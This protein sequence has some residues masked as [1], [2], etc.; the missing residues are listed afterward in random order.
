VLVLVPGHVVASIN[1]SPVN[2]LGEDINGGESVVHGLALTVGEC[3]LSNT[4]SSSWGLVAGVLRLREWVDGLV[5]IRV[6]LLRLGGGVNA[7]PV[8]HWGGPV[9]VRLDIKVVDT[10][11]DSEETLFAPVGAPRVTN[12]PELNTVLDTVTNNGNNVVGIQEAS[13]IVENTTIVVIE[14]LVGGDF[15]SKG[16]TLV[17]FVLNG[18]LTRDVAVLL[19][20]VLVVLLGDD[21][22]SSRSAVSAVRHGRATNTVVPAS[23]LVDRASLVSDVVVEHP[24]VGVTS[25]ATVA[26]VILLLA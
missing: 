12:S 10:S 21:A 23:T 2:L 15:T 14:G 26:T 6:I 20:V 13:L 11:D 19:D 25:I 8:V 1:A 9:T 16:S 17:K 18:G 5:V 7:G 24:F 22:S 4:A 3:C